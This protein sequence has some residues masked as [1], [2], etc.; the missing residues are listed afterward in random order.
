MVHH[1]ATA[2]I[3][4]PLL[5]VVANCSGT[6]ISSELDIRNELVDQICR[7]VQWSRTVDFLGEA[8]VTTFIEFGPGRVLTGIIKRMLRKSTCLNV[9]DADSLSLPL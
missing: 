9:N 6:P 7:P 4:D 3:D 2:A 5:Q 1:V 8:G